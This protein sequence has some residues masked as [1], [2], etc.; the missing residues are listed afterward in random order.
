MPSTTRSEL[1]SIGIDL[2]TG[3]EAD[4][5]SLRLPTLVGRDK[6]VTEIRYL[7]NDPRVRL[8]TL[9]GAAGVGKSRLAQE[10]LARS[11]FGTGRYAAV[12]LAEANNRSEVWNTVLAAAGY[13]GPGEVRQP[14]ELLEAGIGADRTVL[15]MDN[16]DL[17]SGQIAHDISRLLRH[18]PNLLV[19]ATSRIVLNL[20]REYVVYVRPLRTRSD[21]GPNRPASSAAAQLL[22]ASIDSRY[23][24]SA[25]NR[26]V[27]DE[28]AHEVDG[29]PLALELAAITIN[30]IG[31]AQTLKLLRSGA[32]L[33]PLPYVDIPVRHRSLHDAVAWGMNRLD[34]STVDVLLHLSLC[35]SAVDPDTVSLMVDM[36]E[37]FIG[38]TLTTL[39]DHSLVQRT[40]TDAGHPSY[41]LIATVRAYCH[42]LLET[43]RARGDRI[44]RDHVDRLCE[45][46]FRIAGELRRPEQRAAA[47]TIAGQRIDDFRATVAR[48]IAMGRA[49][50]AVEIAGLLED[51]WIRF[52]YLSEI[53][54]LLAAETEL[55]RG[56]ELLGQ[57]ALRS[58]R[59]RRAVELFTRAGEGYRRGNDA[60]GM[61]RIPAR[62]GMAQLEVGR[63][64]RAHEQLT[65]AG[66]TEV[67]EIYLAALAE[68]AGQRDEDWARIRE[69]IR[70]LDADADRLRLYN[71]LAR[72]RLGADTAHRAL[73]LSRDALRIPE[74]GNHIL[75]TLAAVEGCAMAYR[76]AGPEFGDTAAALFGAVH[77]IRTAYAIPLP[78]DTDDLRA[79]HL[80]RPETARD[81]DDV[82][83]CAVAGPEIPA[84]AESPLE[85]LTKRQREIALLVADGL[86]NRMIATRLGI[87]E[88]TVI[89]HLRQVMSK[90]NCPSRLHVALVVKGEQDPVKI[91]ELG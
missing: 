28:I 37:M 32:G 13:G 4:I 25:A 59:S 56:L 36:E 10:V 11:D 81:L 7:I 88:W 64:A 69:R 18:C 30:R 85:A 89:N 86:T 49:D 43:D 87:A 76:M 5:D 23:R 19:V 17:V 15:L 90:L 71:V 2:I 12:D 60:A 91:A 58:G 9:T 1:S 83:A 82:I 20:H 72:T 26:L 16:C 50:R 38:G 78:E 73:E 57:W 67:V 22:L 63:P 53:E 34:D 55:P 74:S 62:L 29:V 31:S 39:I 42:R 45:L 27:L 24:G 35:E 14:L 33:T 40:V 51:V 75:E 65:L 54:R 21:S 47:L 44:R 8:L 80:I 84:P 52:G 79:A 77:H 46:A 48:L 61:Y 66:R 6:E 41:E 70:R 68:P 3:D